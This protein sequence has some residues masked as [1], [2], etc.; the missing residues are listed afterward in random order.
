MVIILAAAAYVRFA[1]IGTWDENQHLHPDERFLTMVETDIAPV[2][3]LAEYFNTG[4]STLNPQNRG[5][6]FFVYGDLP[7]IFVRYL[8]E[9]IDQ[10]GYDQVNILGREVSAVA[11]LITILLVYLIGSRLYKRSVGVLAAAFSAVA[12]LQIQLSH[13]FAVD[14]FANMFT[15]LTIY[16]AV[17][18]YQQRREAADL[19]ADEKDD[20]PITFDT[21][22]QGVRRDWEGTG[23][24][25]LFG[26]ALGCAMASKINAVALAV[27]LPFAA[28]AWYFKA[29]KAEQRR[30]IGPIIRNV[31][32][33][34]IVAFLAFRI[35]QPYAFTGPGFFGLKLNTQWLDNLIELQGQSNGSADF[36][37]ALQWARRSH[38]F[39]IQNM[40]LY[41]MGLPLGILV[42][43]G[44]IWMA[45]RMIKGEWAKHIILWGWVLIYFGWQSMGW[46]PM[47]RYMVLVYPSLAIIGAWLIVQIWDYGVKCE[48]KRSSG[49]LKAAAVTLGGIVLILTSV[50]GYAFST[51]YTRPMTRIAASRWIFDNIPGPINLNY[52]GENGT[53]QQPLA[54]PQGYIIMTDQPFML[55]FNPVQSGTLTGITFFRVLDQ[56]GPQTSS[57]LDI[58]ITQ[59]DNET[60]LAQG[61]ITSNFSGKTDS[62]GAEYSIQFDKAVKLDKDTSYLLM[63]KMADGTGQV[64]M[65]GSALVNE[66]DWDDGLPLRVEGYDGF[67]GI[68]DGNQN[69][70][71]YWDDNAE[72][73][74]R[75]ES[76][77]DNGDYLLIS[78]NRQWGTTTRIP[79]RY[80]L[81]TYYYRNVLGCPAEK[82][83]LWCYQVAKPGMFTGILGYDLVQVYQNDPAIG[84][85]DINDQAAEE[86]FTV[87]DHPKVLI[88]KKS[89]H[90]DSTA[91]HKLLESVDLTKIVHVSLKDVPLRA[92]TLM[93]PADRLAQQQAG[94][95]WTE[96]FDMQALQNKYPVFA[97]IL[98]YLV[99]SIL[100]WFMVP[101]LRLAMPGL[102]DKGYA[103]ARITGMLLLALLSWLAGSAGIA[104]SRGLIAGV[105]VLLLTAGGVAGYLQRDELMEFWRKNK[106]YMLVVEAVILSFFI[107]DLLIRV[108]NPDLWHP[109][110]GGEKPM[111]FSYFNAVIKSTTFPPYDPWMAGGYINYYYYGFVIVGIPVKLLGIEPSIAYNLILPTLF[112][113]LAVGA[114]SI[115]WNIMTAT[116]RAARAKAGEA[117][118][119]TFDWTPVWIGL[120]AAVTIALLGNLGTVRMIW[121]GFQKLAAP[122]GQIDGASVVT[123]WI[124]SIQ[125]FFKFISGSQL[126]YG[127]GEWYWIPSRAI[128]APND[129]E[130]IT[131]FPFFTFLYA[132]M[133]AHMIALPV[134]LLAL[135]WAFSILM[136]KGK[137]GESNGKHFYLS[138][139]AGFLLGGLAIGTLRPTN[140]WDYPTYLVLGLAA[141][142]YT[143]IRLSPSGEP[144]NILNR[145][146]INKWLLTA[147]GAAAL[148]GISLVLYQPFSA[149]YGQG[150]N[151]V[152]LWNG[153]HTPFWSYI[154]HWGL[155]LFIIVS[156]MISETIDWM[157]STPLRALAKF[158]PYKSWIIITILAFI[159]LIVVLSLMGV[160]IAWFVLLL[161]VWALILIFRPGISDL[162][163]AVCFLIGSGLF[164]TLVV[165]IIVLK[166]DIGRMNTVFKFYLQVWTLFAISSGAA[167]GWMLDGMT[168]WK[169][170]WSKIFTT[171]AWIL[172]AGAALF[173]LIAGA[174]K[175]RDRYVSTTSHSLDG[176]NYMI[177]ATWGENDHDLSLEQDYYGI[178]W[179]QQNV[180]GSPVIVEGHT[181]EYHWGSRYS[182]NTGLP[183]V[184]GW[185]WHQAQ[186]RAVTPSEWVDQRVREVDDFYNTTELSD[187]QTFLTKYNVKYIIVGQLEEAIYTPGGIAKFAAQ[188]GKMWKQVFSREDTTIYEVLPQTLAGT[189][190]P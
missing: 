102:P 147:I 69:F 149:W 156:W 38:T 65:T 57:T 181:T 174:D 71:M 53:K 185:R 180:K 183:S 103:F 75:F 114:F 26:V 158:H 93:L 186:Q 110:K 22:W 159:A 132:D 151:A 83:L 20:Q 108:G 188:D 64:T 128:P 82:D 95:T 59:G 86:A 35:F 109:S 116:R 94:G 141:V 142:L 133:H 14:T 169:P 106:K 9:S 121:Q 179:M 61:K 163:R 7:I 32:I 51:I 176:L 118:D 67:G 145:I 120:A 10:T 31:V 150:Y 77:L 85:L 98:W 63:V 89:T 45:W 3:S 124:W 153:T 42:W 81:T 58:S 148:A 88:F 16:I 27:V 84:N 105:F 91:V 160:N 49:W 21:L 177:G 48:G 137:W 162:K 6:S 173:P 172:V 187:V 11:D 139:S 34:A 135:G 154:T 60:P 13:F 30:W 73:L 80:P 161:A 184:V 33:A 138:L 104:V 43:A 166:G 112:S 115:V 15:A 79:E 129:V 55:T 96:L 37:P 1:G 25:I 152:D 146:R 54:Y 167:L 72:K 101:I 23:L 97:V 66:S 123:H 99:L 107:L 134:T 17:L 171:A 87:Y 170:A 2:N 182:I 168:N 140:T 130:P 46:N 122:N 70:Q 131:E 125:G 190:K 92:Q 5:H 189:V 19:D 74:T 28:G 90:Y 47:M 39:A 68:Y 76:A 126:P 143:F 44:F 18:I 117:D 52:S 155:F 136:G 41:G 111:D 144:D 24:Y 78:S 175:I 4:I 50:W 36:P 100:G 164:L 178:R 12:V 56:S 119:E 127:Q 165:E 40:V 157:S 62:R 29:S 8:A 113:L